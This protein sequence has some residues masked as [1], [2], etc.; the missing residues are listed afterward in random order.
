MAVKIG[1]FGLSRGLNFIK[2][3]KLLGLE[4]VAICD[5]D[6]KRLDF[7]KNRCPET[8]KTFTDFEEFIKEDMD[9]VALINFFNEHTP[10]AIR[11]MELGR[12]VLCECTAAS[13]LAEC[14]ELCRAVERT[15]QKFMLAENYPYMLGPKEM[16]KLYR[17]GTLGRVLYSHG[18]YIHPS[19]LEDTNKFT[20][21][22][23]HWRS[24]TPRTYYLTH[25]LG[26]IMYITD[27]FPKTV[28]AV[29][30]SAPELC[31]GTAKHSS[32]GIASM[33]CNMSDGSICSFT[34][35]GAIAGRG[36]WYRIACLDGFVETVRGDGDS[37]CLQYNPWS[38][39]E[40]KFERQTYIPNIEGADHPAAVVRDAGHGGGDYWVMKHFKAVVER[41]EEP[42][43]DVYRSVMMSAV[44]ILAWRSVLE[45]GTTY[46]IPDFK[47]EAD[48]KKYE[49][50]TVT[51]FPK[52]DHSVDIPCC[53]EE[54]HPTEEDMETARKTWK[55]FGIVEIND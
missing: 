43:F 44:A 6:Q 31:K 45:G 55:K 52:A 9:A 15:G 39:P 23:Y 32:D 51:P 30:A 37:V 11:A 1:I 24:W 7:A 14:V 53:K 4:I 41:K 20:R 46:E 5:M 29:S 18:E 54:Y 10:F 28:T 48:R 40:G 8:T 33:L 16:E 13:T 42:Y 22:E 25:S 49:N 38:I 35:A 17:E 3:A 21:G 36:N 34:G 19:S 50:D 47:N 26:P 27:A 2:C 12:D